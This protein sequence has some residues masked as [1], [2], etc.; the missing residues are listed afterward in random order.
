MASITKKQYGF[1]VHYLFI[2]FWKSVLD[3]LL[4]VG[5][6]ISLLFGVLQQNS[7]L[8]FAYFRYFASCESLAYKKIYRFYWLS[9]IFAFS[10]P[11][12]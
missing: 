8:N 10:D 3:E 2:K 5:C 9:N 4:N 12:M 6:W 11:E 1:P 7:V